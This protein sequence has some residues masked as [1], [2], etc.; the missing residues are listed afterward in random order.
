MLPLAA[1]EEE[2][3]RDARQQALPPRTLPGSIR[4]SNVIG[5][6]YTFC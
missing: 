2:G 5:R 6:D 3:V 1:A 4:Y